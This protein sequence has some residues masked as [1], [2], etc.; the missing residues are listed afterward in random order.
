MMLQVATRGKLPQDIWGTDR[1]TYENRYGPLFVEESMMYFRS[2]ELHENSKTRWYQDDLQISYKLS[3]LGLLPPAH[4]PPRFSVAQALPKETICNV[5]PAGMHKTWMTPGI[6]PTVIV[7][8][9]SKPFYTIK[10]YR[11]GSFHAKYDI[12]E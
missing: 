7:L 5:D 12:D 1:R 9:L 10:N 3:M 6:N 4:I 2:D 11:T 8:L